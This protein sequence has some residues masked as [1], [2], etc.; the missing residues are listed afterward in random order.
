MFENFSIEE[1]KN[2][3]IL[4]AIVFMMIVYYV[5]FRETP[6]KK[7]GGNK[8]TVIYLFKADWC[9]HCKTS[10]LLGKNEKKI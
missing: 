10:C 3:L 4:G 6:E 9:P 5:F 7:I 1:N 8:I 2:M